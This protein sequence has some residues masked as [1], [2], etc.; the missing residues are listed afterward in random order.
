MPPNPELK[1]VVVGVGELAVSS[2]PRESIVTYALGSCIAV[3]AWSP[4]QRSGGLVHYM[5]PRSAIAP[6]KAKVTPAM[7]ADTG[8]PALFHALYALGCKKESL[9]IKVA[10]GGTLLEGVDA[11]DIGRSNTEAL[12]PMFKRAGVQV[13]AW[14]VG[15]TASR[16]VELHMGTGQVLVSS[17]GVE[18][19][20]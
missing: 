3:I 6:A 18:H 20:L 9:I 2:N 8:V 17:R 1:R 10:G 5:L 19:N 4:V 7:F 16:T 12:T 11:F 13:A 15:G 14:E